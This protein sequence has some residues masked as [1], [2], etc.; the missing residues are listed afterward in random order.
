MLAGE[1]PFNGPTPQ[2]I[3]ARVMT[4]EPRSLTMQRHTIPPH[5]DAAVRM[6]LEKLPADRFTSAAAFAESLAG[7][8]PVIPI[9]RFGTG[10]RAAATPG[11]TDWRRWFL[12]AAGVGVLAIAALA[13]GWVQT[14]K[15]WAP[16]WTYITMGDSLTMSGVLPGLAISPDGATLVVRDNIQNGRLWVK[17]RGDLNAVPIAGTE[18]ASAPVF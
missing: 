14:R 8:G 17:R 13:W 11:G 12:V 5:V 7:L 10:A 9:T 4:E 2:A 18:R 3:I 15:F 6:A 16:T 1:P